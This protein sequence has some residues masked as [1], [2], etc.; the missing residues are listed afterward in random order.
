NTFVDS[1]FSV[2]DVTFDV[3]AGRNKKVGDNTNL[4]LGVFSGVQ[5]TS[6]SGDYP[7]NGTPDSEMWIEIPRITGGV[8]Q[9]VG[10]WVVF[11]AGAVS[12]TNYYARGDFNQFTTNFD[13]N[14]GVGLHWDNFIV[15]ATINEGFLHDGPYMVGGNA[16]GFMGS[17]AATYNF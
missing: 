13:T 16:N 9:E 12:T 10:K 11:R 6:Y 7:E 17:L 4:V 8:E 14:F 5:S 3:G 2:T 1:S 15:D